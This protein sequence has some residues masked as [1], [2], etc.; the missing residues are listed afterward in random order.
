MNMNTFCARKIGRDQR[1]MTL[2]EIVAVM[3]VLVILAAVIVP[4]LIRKMD[5]VAGDQESAS[6]KGL[7]DALQSSIL[8]HRYIPSHTNWA[9]VVATERGVNLSD[10]NTNL[11]RQRRVCLVDPD[12]R[13]GSRTAGMDYRQDNYGSVTTNGSG[14]VIPPVSPRLILLSSIGEP[15]PAGVT[16]GVPD[17]ANFNG[18]WNAPDGAL[19]AGSLWTG[20]RGAQD[21]RVQRVNL[22]SLFVHLVLTSY[23]S[24]DGTGTNRVEGQYAI[25]GSALTNAPDTILDPMGRDSYFLQNSILGLYSYTNS[26][27]TEQILTRDISFVYQQNVWRASIEG[28][29]SAGGMD[30]G[31]I[32]DRFLR[33]P[34]N[35]NPN[36]SPTQQIDIVQAMM[37]YMEAYRNWENAGFP[38]SPPNLLD[39]AEDKQ[40]AM[41]LL[42]QGLYQ[43][44][45]GANNY[46]PPQVDCPP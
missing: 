28:L 6:L 22:S 25:D 5:Q 1:A 13:I 36:V 7:A 29:G 23:T 16:N 31:N 21:L 30:I 18:I 9:Q 33:A 46:A 35:T 38:T 11:R 15:L 40:Q 10:V 32:V 45:G 41:M 20:W 39:T 2:I 44:G 26:L 12:L 27:D 14:G 37:E 43:Y 3:V 4:V 17:A 8:R 42:V 34:N 19:P 24:F